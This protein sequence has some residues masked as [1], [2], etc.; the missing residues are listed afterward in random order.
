MRCGAPPRPV[1]YRGI[2]PR[3]AARRRV[4]GQA[5]PALCDETRRES[6]ARAETADRP[7]GGSS[8]HPAPRH[9]RP[10]SCGLAAARALPKRSPS[11]AR[12][13]Y[14]AGFELR[15]GPQ[16][17]D[18]LDAQQQPPAQRVREVRIQQRRKRMAEMQPAHS[19][20]G[21]KRK[22]GCVDTRRMISTWEA[23]DI[24]GCEAR[25]SAP[26]STTEFLFN[27]GQ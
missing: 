12:S 8:V 7:S 23:F 19:G 13:S 5:R 22:T 25:D 17:V 26:H 15:A 27:A 21:A 24:M 10:I 11:Q 3:E 6:R 9:S 2:G 14:I 1:R 18:I 20:S 16:R 4:A